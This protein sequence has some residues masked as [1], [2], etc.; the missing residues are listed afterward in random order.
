MSE[1]N[2]Q[3]EPIVP[4][5]ASRRRINRELLALAREA[6]GLS[7]AELAAALGSTQSRV[8]K[9]ESGILELADADLEQIASVLE[10]P[11]EFFFLPDQGEGFGTACMY[12]RKRQS[13]SVKEL[14]VI[15]ANINIIRIHLTRLLR[16]VEIDTTNAFH[17]MDIDE[18]GGSPE[19]IA[20]LLRGTW[21][22]P[23]GPIRCLVAAIENAGGIVIPSDFGT[24]KL[25][26]V[27]HWP[28][29]MP[30]LF[31]INRSIPVDR[32][33][34][35]LAH[36]LGH[37][38]MHRIPTPNAEQE[39]DRFA[40]EFLMPE[41]EVASDLDGMSIARAIQLKPYW[42]VSAQALIRRA[43]E[44]GK[45]D[46]S[47]YRS[48]YTQMSM[49][50]YRKNEPEPLAPESPTVA[51]DLIRVHRQQ[52]GF[53]VPQLSKVT[54]CCEKHFVRIFLDGDTPTLRVIG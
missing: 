11:E 27:S 46:E 1:P 16:G 26:A 5:D 20:R 52:L 29:T 34:W 31:F 32:W 7:Q 36:E 14:R 39:A 2:P 54:H 53:T 49:L 6:R 24:N 18:Y 48:L 45:I 38:V 4:A 10:F 9:L 17:R 40:S 41:R 23:I 50:G 22:L 44:V 15:H 12:H 35:T 13:L 25:D 51:R 47:R 8:S 33:R 21:K 37:V 30:P 42:R 43:K 3:E 28:R 19:T